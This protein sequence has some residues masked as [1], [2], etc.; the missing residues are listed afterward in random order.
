MREAFFTSGFFPWKSPP[1][2]TSPPPAPPLAS[3]F[4]LSNNPTLSPRSCTFPPFA[5]SDAPTTSMLPLK[6]V[7]SADRNFTTPPPSR[8]AAVMTEPRSEVTFLAVIMID[9]PVSL[10]PSRLR[11][12]AATTPVFRMSPSPPVSVTLPSPFST[13]PVASI[14]PVFLIAIGK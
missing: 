13:N 1:T 11:C 3:T 9:P 5:F 12:N 10:C 7:V 4:A 14:T 8:P 2:R 6:I